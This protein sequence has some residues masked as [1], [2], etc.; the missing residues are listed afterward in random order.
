MLQTPPLP[1]THA[2]QCTRAGECINVLT[3]KYKV[4]MDPPG[5]QRALHVGGPSGPT[6]KLKKLRSHQPRKHSG[7]KPPETPRKERAGQPSTSEEEGAAATS[8]QEEP[9]DEPASLWIQL[10]QLTQAAATLQAQMQHA[11]HLP[12]PPIPGT[13]PAHGHPGQ[14]VPPTPTGKSNGTHFETIFRQAHQAISRRMPRFSNWH[15][16]SSVSEN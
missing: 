6:V 9:Q 11:A 5:V 3:V 2:H 13:A 4:T 12:P 1:P 14:R 7:K 16:R 8:L 15:G 10:S